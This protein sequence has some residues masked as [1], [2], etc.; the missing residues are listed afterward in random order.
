MLP[1]VCLWERDERILV[2]QHLFIE[3]ISQHQ[4]EAVT[5]GGTRLHSMSEKEFCKS[6]VL[7]KSQHW[8]ESVTQRSEA[9]FL[10]TEIGQM[11]FRGAVAKDL[12]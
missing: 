9:L 3:L 5:R 6:R 10:C 7:V 11:D 8:H 4:L 12:A 1:N 2:S